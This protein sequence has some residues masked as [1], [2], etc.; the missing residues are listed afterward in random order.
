MRILIVWI[1]MLI[2]LPGALA[3]PQITFDA[4]N[5]AFQAK[6]YPEAIAQYE[7]LL[8][9][10]YRDE[11]L[12]YNL[13]N[14]YYAA[15][16]V[17]KAILHFERALLLDPDDENTRYNLAVARYHVQGEIDPVPPFFLLKWWRAARSAM[18]PSAWGILALLL[19]WAGL[20]GLTLWQLGKIRQHKKRGFLAGFI[21]IALSL[22][23]L[24][25]ALSAYQHRNDTDEGILVVQQASL[26]SGA[27]ETS[28]ELR[29]IYEGTRLEL[30]DQINIWYKV[31]L[32]N[33]ETGW[34]SGDSF[35]EI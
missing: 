31:R 14:S 29:L 35:E 13:G 24:S 25:L 12:Y 20:G 5:K 2:L 21:A 10:G 15:G 9:E 26:K 19:F 1:G 17:G 32:E 30:L 28:Q 3:Q 8:A 27:D 33:G 4:A 18:S 23:P 11:A 7:Q 6:N 16:Q 34:L 22:V